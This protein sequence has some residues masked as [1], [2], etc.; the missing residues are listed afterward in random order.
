M[1]R[2]GRVQLGA[3]ADI[4]IFD[5]ETIIDNADF[6]SGLVYS[7]GVEYVLVDGEFVVFDGELVDGA[8]P[9]RAV[10][11]RYQPFP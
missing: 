7:T 2:K 3:D 5:A 10:L 11:G 8:R 6:Q 1:K 9:G 4:T